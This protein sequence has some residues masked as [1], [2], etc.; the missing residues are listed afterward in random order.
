MKVRVRSLAGFRHI[1][2]KDTEVEL[3]EGIRIEDLLQNLC[4]AREGLRPLLF[5]DSGLKGDVNILVNGRNV[6]SLQGLETEL[7]EGDDV[8]LFPAAIGG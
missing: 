6:E 2:G 5:E 8:A 3:A 1:L 4:A 7:A